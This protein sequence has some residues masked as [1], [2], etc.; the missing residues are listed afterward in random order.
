MFPSKQIQAHDIINKLKNFFNRKIVVYALKYVIII[1]TITDTQVSYEFKDRN[2]GFL[3]QHTTTYIPFSVK[4]HL[5][6]PKWKNI[7]IFLSKPKEL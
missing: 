3:N 4:V 5:P 6:K 1:S 7:D 2:L